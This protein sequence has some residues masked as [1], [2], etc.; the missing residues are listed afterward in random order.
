MP[1]L[2]WKAYI[3]FEVEEGERARARELYE[4]LAMTSGHWKVWVAYAMF[5]AQPMQLPR[6]EREEDDDGD[7]EKEPKMADGDVDLAR[8]IFQKGYKELKSKGLKNE[9]NTLVAFT[10]LRPP[11]LSYGS[12]MIFC[13]CLVAR[14]V[15]TSME[16]LRGAAWHSR[17]YRQG[18]EHDARAGQATLRRRGDRTT[19]GR[20]CIPA[21]SHDTKSDM[22][23]L[24]DYDY[25]FAD[26]ERESNPTSF[27]FLQMAHAWAAAKKAG[28]AGSA[29]RSGGGGGGGGG[30]LSRFTTALGHESE[31]DSRA[32]SDGGASDESMDEDVD[33]ASVA[34]SQ[35]DTKKA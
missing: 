13:L 32:E 28:G 34:S 30:A 1:E 19:R 35:D 25:I 17:R 26:D 22:F 6:D 7:E 23:S 5:E 3:D 31:K 18:G 21:H 11:Q 12:L 8:Q 24:T 10:S 16:V 9:V 15:V 33:V 4:R 29:L 20:Y 14:C 27:K 2:L